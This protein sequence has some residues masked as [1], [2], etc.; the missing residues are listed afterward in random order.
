M[1]E[2]LSLT[3][4]NAANP[5]AQRLL[6][7]AQTQQLGGT[8]VGF[9]GLEEQ[10][11]KE[12]INPALLMPPTDQDKLKRI[13]AIAPHEYK[14]ESYPKYA[15]VRIVEFTFIERPIDNHSLTSVVNKFGKRFSYLKEHIEKYGHKWENPFGVVI[16]P[17]SLLFV[18]EFKVPKSALSKENLDVMAEEI[19]QEEGAKFMGFLEGSSTEEVELI[20]KYYNGLDYGKIEHPHKPVFEG[21]RRIEEW[22]IDKMSGNKLWTLQ[23]F[24]TPHFPCTRDNCPWEVQGLSKELDNYLREKT[25]EY[26]KKLRTLAIVSFKNMMHTVIESMMLPYDGGGGDSI[27]SLSA[28]TEQLNELSELLDSFSSRRSSSSAKREKDTK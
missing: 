19:E 11:E 14:D 2:N 22:S 20:A 9:S 15:S 5:I 6:Q 18:Q 13:W 23:L 27:Q 25:I 7:N 16:M 21:D 8:S 28:K 26:I 10:E 24:F 3:S 17:I 4:L 12:F 1:S